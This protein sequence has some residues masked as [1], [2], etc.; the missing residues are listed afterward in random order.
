MNPAGIELRRRARRIER[1]A[2]IR[3]AMLV[4]TAMWCFTLAAWML[5]PEPDVPADNVCVA[6]QSLDAGGTVTTTPIECM[7]AP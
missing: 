4:A 3:A 1:R 7:V 5:W 2:R 6:S